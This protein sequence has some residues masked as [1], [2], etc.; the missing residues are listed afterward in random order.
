MCT[1]ERPTRKYTDRE[2]LATRNMLLVLN[3]RQGDLL[4]TFDELDLVAN[5]VPVAFVG[6]YPTEVKG[7]LKGLYEHRLFHGVAI[8]RSHDEDDLVLVIL[9]GGEHAEMPT[10]DYCIQRPRD[11]EDEDRD[12]N[13]DGAE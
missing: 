8:S 1:D 5:E 3:L 11:K 9:P 10:N 4:T 7:D 13:E 2:L 6:R 12:L